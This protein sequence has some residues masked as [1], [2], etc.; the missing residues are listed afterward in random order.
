MNFKRESEPEIPHSFQLTEN[1]FRPASVSV[2]LKQVM[3]NARLALLRRSP[4]SEALPFGFTVN[5]CEIKLTLTAI[6]C[7]NALCIWKFNCFYRR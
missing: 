5:S 6:G 7:I 4:D 1:S 2:T 3:K